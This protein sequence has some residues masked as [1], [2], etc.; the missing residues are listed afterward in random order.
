MYA[1]RQK[2]YDWKSLLNFILKGRGENKKGAIC[3]EGAIRPVV[4]FKKFTSIKPSEVSPKVF[5]QVIE[6]MGAIK[7][8]NKRV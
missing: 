8:A 6:A 1:H 2:K 4:E 7:T 3:S 5:I